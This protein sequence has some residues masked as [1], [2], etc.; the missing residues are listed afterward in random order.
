[1]K[2]I[3][4]N[5]NRYNLAILLRKI[6]YKY[7]GETEKQEFNM[8]RQLERGG[9]PRF[10]VYLKITPE[11]L[12]FSLHLDQRKPVYKGAPAHSADYEGKAVEQEA[13]RIKDSLP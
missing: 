10:H 5:T 9:Y 3:I 2:F 4:K 12:S 1:M 6:G 11:E 7:L 8:I 13:Q